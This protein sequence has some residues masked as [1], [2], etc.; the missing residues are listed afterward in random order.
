MT[1]Y[2]VYLNLDGRRVVVI[3]GGRI[4]ERK[5]EGLLATRAS[6][7]VISPRIT[8]RVEGLVRS[9]LIEWKKRTYASGDCAGA[10]LVFSATGDPFVRTAVF[11]EARAAR[12]IV[13]TVD[14]PAFCDFIMPAVI[15]RGDLTVAISTAGSSPALAARLRRKLSKILGQEYARML[16]LMSRVRP[17]IRRR[18]ED[19]DDRKDVHYRIVS[20]E[21]LGLLKNKDHDAAD[22]RVREIMDEFALQEK[23]P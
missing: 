2:P 4:A 16:E 15:R 1:F 8:R 5:I 11:E 23:V 17:E 9:K 3:G 10:A 22:R 18:F 7:V 14:D 13:N 19:P 12:I 21:V 20:S 6:I